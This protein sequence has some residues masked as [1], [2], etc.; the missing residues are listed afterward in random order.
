MSV[1][2]D[3]DVPR[4]VC[5]RGCARRGVDLYGC[6]DCDPPPL[7]TL[8]NSRVRPGSATAKQ[9]DQGLVLLGKAPRTRKRPKLPTVAEIAAML[10]HLRPVIDPVLNLVRAECPD[11]RGGETDPQ[12]MWLPLAVMASELDGRVISFC[13][14][15]GRRDV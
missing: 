4:L 5:A 14:G 12:G 1:L 15:C 10:A 13:D 2:R 11:C 6:P 8:P 7:P 3:Q 9:I